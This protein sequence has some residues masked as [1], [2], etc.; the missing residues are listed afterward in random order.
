MYIPCQLETEKGLSL[1]AANRLAH[2]YFLR[3][4]LKIDA[5]L[6]NLCFVGDPR[7]RTTQTDLIF[8]H[9]TPPAE[10]APFGTRCACAGTGADHHLVRGSG[11]NLIL[12]LMKGLAASAALFDDVRSLVLSVRQTIARGVDLLQVQ[13]NFEMADGSWNRSNTVRIVLNT[14]KKS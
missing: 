12:H 4:V 14:A 2:L 7:T 9:S 11:P 6:V 1:S 3:D 13:T 8:A 10:N 5:Y